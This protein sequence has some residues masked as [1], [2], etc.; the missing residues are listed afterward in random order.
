MGQGSSGSTAAAHGAALSLFREPQSLRTS[1]VLHASRVGMEGES[2]R[3]LRQLAPQRF[4]PGIRWPIAQARMTAR[5][6]LLGRPIYH[7]SR[8][9]LCGQSSIRSGIKIAGLFLRTILFLTLLTT[10]HITPSLNRDKS[11]GQAEPTG[12]SFL[13]GLLASECL[14]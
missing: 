8:R 1:S 11:V 9:E 4:M 2:Q 3:R 7:G 12:L 14:A 6:V 5:S 13:L 10:D